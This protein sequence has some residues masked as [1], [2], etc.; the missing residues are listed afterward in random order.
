MAPLLLF[1]ALIGAAQ[2]CSPTSSTTWEPI[3]QQTPPLGRSRKR[4]TE[5]VV[6]TVV[7]NRKFDPSLNDTHMQ[8]MKSLLDDYTKSKG[9]VY[10]K[11]MVKE[12]VKNVGGQFA[13]HYTVQNA[14]CGEVLFP[15]EICCATSE[16]LCTRGEARGE[17]HH[18]H[19]SQM[20][21][22]ASIHNQLIDNRFVWRNEA[23]KK[24]C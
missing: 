9:V 2:A 12:A 20:R 5:L 14:D 1:L 16:R 6:V 18:T 22:Q 15:T 8:T 4:A 17:L 19:E 11:R 10:D 7:T 24:Y 13:V 21:R 3:T 23:D